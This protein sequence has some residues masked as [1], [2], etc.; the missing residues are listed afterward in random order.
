MI[1]ANV[2][3]EDRVK[4]KILDKHGITANEIKNALAWKPMVLKTRQKRYMAIGF[5]YRYITIVFEYD[6]KTANIVTSYPSSEWQIKL[7]KRKGD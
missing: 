4:E 5:H 6:R 1:I 7:Y 3:I 2:I